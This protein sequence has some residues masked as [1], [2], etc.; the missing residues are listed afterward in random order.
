M[1]STDQVGGTRE[2]V[3]ERFP[4]PVCWAPAHPVYQIFDGRPSFGVQNGV[5]VCVS[6]AINQG[7]W[8][9]RDVTI[10]DGRNYV[11]FQQRHMEHRV[12]LNVWWQVE[13]KND[14]VNLSRD[15]EWADLMEVK[16]F[17][18]AGRLEIGGL[19]PD[20][21]TNLEGVVHVLLVSLGHHGGP[22]V[23]Q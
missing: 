21:V 18:R 5:H 16:L 1:E 11:G 17:T 14:R 8:G 10:R 6:L 4:G 19:K 15:A 23:F 22:G 13:T 7:E 2:D 9:R 3:V 12:Q 20:H